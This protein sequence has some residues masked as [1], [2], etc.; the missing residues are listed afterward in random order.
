[1]LEFMAL[2]GLRYS[3][4]SRL[5]FTDVMIN[6]VFRDSLV[7]IQIK[8]FNKRIAAGV[9]ASIAKERSKVTLYLNPQCKDLLADALGLSNRNLGLI[10]ESSKKAGSPYTAQYV[11][12][13]LKVVAGKLKLTF[14][15]STHSFRKAFA[16]MLINQN[17]KIHQVRDA[18]GQSSLA[19]TD[20]YLKTFISESQALSNKISF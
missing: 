11:N 6:G 4:V 14:A 7:V 9:K 12:R 8:P 18:L 1:M 15:L 5:K 20:A 16:L 10:F 17:A 2:T 13:T 3:D 19:S